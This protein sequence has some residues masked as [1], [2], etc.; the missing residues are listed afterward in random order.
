MSEML[1]IYGNPIINQVAIDGSVALNLYD[2][3]TSSGIT[4]FPTPTNYQ[5]WEYATKVKVGSPAEIEAQ[6]KFTFTRP[7]AMAS[8]G[9]DIRFSTL[10]RVNV[11]YFLESIVGDQ[12]TVWLKAP[13]NDT[14][15]IMYYGNS[16]AVSES[17]LSKVTDALVH[18]A[19]DGDITDESGNAYSVSSS[20]ITLT[21][22]S[23]GDADSAAAIPQ[24]SY[25]G[26]STDDS[27][28]NNAF[29]Y[30]MK[31]TPEAF[32]D[33]YSGL[34]IGI[35]Q[36]AAHSRLLLHRDWMY[37][38]LYDSSVW[39]GQSSNNAMTLGVESEIVITFDGTTTK[40][41][42][43]GVVE[44][45]STSAD[46]SNANIATKF[47]VGFTNSTYGYIGDM[48]D[49]RIYNRCLSAIE[50]ENLYSSTLSLMVED[51]NP[52]YL[53][54]THNHMQYNKA[55]DIT[56]A[57]AIDAQYPIDITWVSGM[58]TDFGD[59]RI[60]TDDGVDVPLWRESYTL[61]STA[62]FWIKV[63]ADTS[64]I[65]VYYGNSS[66]N[67][68]GDGELVFETFDNFDAQT[69]ILTETDTGVI[70]SY[71]TGKDGVGYGLELSGGIGY[72]SIL[73]QE[74]Y[75]SDIVVAVDIKLPSPSLIGL[76]GVM[77]GW[78]NSGNTGRQ[79]IADFRVDIDSP[80]IETR[81]DY[82]VNSG[83][84][85]LKTTF[86]VDTW[87]K[88]EASV[89]GTSL[90]GKLYESNGTL[91]T[92]VTSVI[93]EGVNDA[94]AI[95]LCRYQD[96]VFDNFRVSKYLSTDPT[97]TWN[98]QGYTIG[99]CL[100]DWSLFEHQATI[101]VEDI[102]EVHTPTKFTFTKADHTIN[103][104]LSDLRCCDVDGNYL[105]VWV[106]EN[107]TTV[108]A[109]TVVPANATRFFMRYGYSGATSESNGHSIF[110][111]IEAFDG[112][113]LSSIWT[114]DVTRD[115]NHIVE[116]GYIQITDT[117]YG[118]SLNW[119]YNRTDDGCQH[120][121]NWV[122]PNR[123]TLEWKS[124]FDVE[125]MAKF[126]VAL[127]DS[128][129]NLLSAFIS[130]GDANN[131]T[132]PKISGF[133]ETND[134]SSQPAAYGESCRFKYVV[135]NGVV[136]SYYMR[137]GE[138][139]WTSY[140][141]DEPATFDKVAIAACQWDSPANGMFEVA[142]IYHIYVLDAIEIEPTLYVL[143]EGYSPEFIVTPSNRTGWSKRVTLTASNNH[144]ERYP[145]KKVIPYDADMKADY[146][147][148][149]FL[150]TI[151]Y[152]RCPHWVESYDGTEAVV[153]ILVPIAGDIYMY[154]GDATATSNSNI[155]QVFILGDE[156][157]G[158]VGS[159][160]DSNKWIP[161]QSGT[162][163]ATIELDGNGNLL[164]EGESSVSSSA[165]I[166]STLSIL[167]GI[168]VEI[169]EKIETQYY[170]DTSIGYGE[171]QGTWHTT[172]VDGIH[173]YWQNAV[174][175]NPSSV[176]VN[177][178]IN[179][180]VDI[181]NIGFATLNT[182]YH[183]RIFYAHNGYTEEQYNGGTTVAD[184]IPDGLDKYK[185]ILISQG[186]YV[187]NRAGVRTIDW[188]G[189]REYVATEPSLAIGT[190]E[191]NPDAAG[192]PTIKYPNIF[193]GYIGFNF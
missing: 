173:V 4:A 105:P 44:V 48:D 56:D 110:H 85:G 123:F 184:N 94:G 90:I 88:I 174:V 5:A 59:I 108:T 160:P 21:T 95:G 112:S 129:D 18:I 116:N 2:V 100:K 25:I 65:R 162:T 72:R 124:Y 28:S 153:W 140:I 175:G 57:P 19:I 107:D 50:V 152:R 101:I 24:A 96:T 77:I 186:Q 103:T 157:N 68:A 69:S 183:R 89:S 40:L 155:E 93:T 145:I 58:Q 13:A 38:N 9:A 134:G 118:S 151:A 70:S 63:P 168:S 47:G 67:Y 30:A 154:Y 150:D 126:G 74:E 22:N 181:H 191:S 144:T 185:N 141:T 130:Q 35:N 156:F 41:Y 49:I 158:V 66:A 180:S 15:L 119:I 117:S 60:A 55:V 121:V 1:D 64:R 99:Y 14:R 102:P 51:F 39:L 11:P 113:A 179:S 136:S 131:Y 23:D 135:D 62:K 84:E 17:D 46:W 104:D 176:L 109:W 182:Y 37:L 52:Y 33:L 115:L 31:A 45:E 148:L 8:D 43:D 172:L 114:E 165:N 76:S 187:D 97:F 177:E 171:L 128:A 190:E 163:S 3:T 125:G 75:T 71:V 53:G 111:S 164:L 143:P 6:V 92:S 138:T 98:P 82:V 78:E 36:S 189:I 42:V 193:I 137:E 10:D 170:A 26:L 106:E 32:T 73:T 81:V 7:S 166:L 87:Y 91:V 192:E 27:L 29:T 80:N 178:F 16:S 149:E 146:S 20:G 159:S 139:D 132:N 127:V 86:A 142:R 188:V 133:V 34:M 79:V 122:L 61:G 54:Y 161:K 167:N 83:D 169:R 147:D 12:V 120:Q